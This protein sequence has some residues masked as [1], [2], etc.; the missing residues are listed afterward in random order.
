MVTTQARATLVL[1]LSL[2][3]SCGTTNTSQTGGGKSCPDSSSDTLTKQS[4]TVKYQ[5]PAASS[6]TQLSDTQ[7]VDIPDQ[8]RVIVKDSNGVGDLCLRKD[9]QMRYAT[10]EMERVLKKTLEKNVGFPVDLVTRTP[11]AALL[12]QMSGKTRCTVVHNV[13]TPG[14]P[15][16]VLVCDVATLNANASLTT[17]SP[18]PGV[19]QAIS[20]CNPDPLI[21]IALFP[22]STMSLSVQID[23]EPPIV[24]DPG[25]EFQLDAEPP[26][27]QAVFNDE[28]VRIFTEQAK[29][30]GIEV[31]SPATPAS[32][33]PMSPSPQASS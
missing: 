26:V 30:L 14:A 15:S 2:A 12:N 4:G 9:D 3:T 22:T 8:S 29:E 18:A 13:P 21:H 23:D 25:C 17:P 33:E 31:Q 6:F 11:T 32:C 5:G 7:T 28:D 10:C 27:Q 20:A 24:V 16:S 1:A 19:I